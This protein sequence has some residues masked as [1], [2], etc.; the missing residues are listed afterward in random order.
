MGFQ[1]KVNQ[2]LAPAVEGDFADHSIRAQQLADEGGLVAGSNGVVVGRFAWV[3]TDGTVF[4][5]GTIAPSGF[6]HR[7]QQ[8]L[9]TAYL[10]ESSMV[11][12]PF[13]MV[14]VMTQGAYWA[15]TTT[16]ATVG[17]KIF[18][19]TTD[20]SIA[21]GTAGAT[22]A[23]FVETE[24]YAGSTATAG[25]LIKISTFIYGSQIPVPQATT[26]ASQGSN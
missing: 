10:G 14:T 13:T 9:I 7:E 8:A 12:P 26:T 11:I 15:K 25:S 1:T 3:A 20:G 18:A 23:G 2:Y 16:N 17:Q 5:A 21:T 4:N 22:V 19:S 6:I 24:F